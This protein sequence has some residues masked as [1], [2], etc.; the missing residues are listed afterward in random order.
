MGLCF[1]FVFAVCR[2]FWSRSFFGFIL[3]GIISFVSMFR[4]GEVGVLLAFG[5]W[6]GGIKG[7]EWWGVGKRVVFCLLSLLRWGFR[8]FGRMYWFVEVVSGVVG[9]FVVA[10]VGLGGVVVVAV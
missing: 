3:R 7:F 10:M 1:G 8:G 6:R 2:C 9:F 5:F 4:G